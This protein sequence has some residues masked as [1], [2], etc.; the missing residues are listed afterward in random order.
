MAADQAEELDEVVRS[1]RLLWSCECERA[2]IAIRA[3]DRW[4]SCKGRDALLFR[5]LVASASVL[6]E[7]DRRAKH[8]RNKERTSCFFSSSLS[9]STPRLASNWSIS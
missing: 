5:R 8:E 7:P 1:D 9:S 4:E 3:G 6:L 2:L